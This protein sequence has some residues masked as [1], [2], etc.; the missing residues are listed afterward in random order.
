MIK[1]LNTAAT[2]MR[3]QITNM[4]TT[5]NNM[6]NVSTLGFKKSRAEFEDLMYQDLKTQGKQENSPLTP[7]GNSNPV[8]TQVGN[9]VKVSSIEKDFSQGS[10]K[11]TNKA[12]DLEIQ[13][14]GFFVVQLPDGRQ[15]YTR[16]GAFKKGADGRLQDRNGNILQ[17]EIVIPPTAVAVEIGRDGQVNVLESEGEVPQNVGQIQL[18]S[19]SNPAGL[20][21]VGRNL[22]MASQSSGPPQL[23]LS[24]EGVFGSVLQGQLE[25]S[26]VNIVDEMVNMITTQRAYETNAKVIQASDEMLRQINTLR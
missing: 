22:F 14:S 9:G 23:G 25:T 10:T 11:V 15:A 16:D 17:S 12:F 7:G 21:S 18:A 13:G 2:G 4:D 1:A 8:S 5:A 26:N 3:A 6:A 19:F 24:G 20:F